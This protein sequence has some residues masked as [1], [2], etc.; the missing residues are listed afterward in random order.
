MAHLVFLAGDSTSFSNCNVILLS[1]EE[2]DDV[3]RHLAHNLAMSTFL[4][5]LSKKQDSQTK[6]TARRLFSR[7]SLV[8]D[9]CNTGDDDFAKC[10]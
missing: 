9:T 6:C 5:Y 8:S 4:R 7:F 3:N 10:Q 1:W 2:G